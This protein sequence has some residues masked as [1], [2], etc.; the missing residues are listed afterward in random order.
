MKEAPTDVK[1]RWWAV[2]FVANAVFKNR[3]IAALIWQETLLV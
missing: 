1:L 3:E 2:S